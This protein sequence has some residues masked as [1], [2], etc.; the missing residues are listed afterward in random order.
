M[1][2]GARS[3]GRGHTYGPY[4]AHSSGDYYDRHI[5]RIIDHTSS[6]LP[7]TPYQ[8]PQIFSTPPHYRN[9]ESLS[10]GLDQITDDQAEYSGLDDFGKLTNSDAVYKFIPRVTRRL[11]LPRL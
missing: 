11:T 5:Q 1:S 9:R 10:G 4:D 7:E 8:M 2:Q 3:N 6:L